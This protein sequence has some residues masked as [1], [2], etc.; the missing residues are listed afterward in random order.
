MDHPADGPRVVALLLADHVYRDGTSGKH[1]VAGTF[2]HLEAPSLPTTFTGPVCVFA[3]LLGLR[4]PSAMQ[5][6]L[7]EP[8]SDEVLL[9]PLAFQVGADDSGLT[10]EFALQLP[11]LPLPR[12]GRYAIRLSSGSGTLGETPLH[13]VERAGS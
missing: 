1:V 7:V 10:V 3:A 12:A 8:G 13:V 4:E 6:S 5:V 9:G 11:P 2:N